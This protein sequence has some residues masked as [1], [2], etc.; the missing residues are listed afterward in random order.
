VANG[1]QKGEPKFP[2][3]NHLL[4]QGGTEIETKVRMNFVDG[5]VKSGFPFPLKLKVKGNQKINNFANF[6]RNWFSMK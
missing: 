1:Q 6:I 5:T 4:R 3:R 2:K